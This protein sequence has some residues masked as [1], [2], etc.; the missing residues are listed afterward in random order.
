M[1]LEHHGAGRWQ[2][3]HFSAARGLRVPALTVNQ[4]G[5]FSTWE[6]AV[7]LSPLRMTSVCAEFVCPPASP[8][9][10]S[11]ACSHAKSIA[12]SASLP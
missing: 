8:A 11:Q 6:N 1:A 2:L 4:G 9:P 7:G 5:K 12:R 10:P 3:N